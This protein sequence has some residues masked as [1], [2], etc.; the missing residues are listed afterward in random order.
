[1][2]FNFLTH[3]LSAILSGFQWEWLSH[4]SSKLPDL[5]LALNPLALPSR[6]LFLLLYGT[7][8]VY[9]VRPLGEPWQMEHQ[10]L[11]VSSVP[12]AALRVY[13]FCSVPHSRLP[14]GG[15]HV[16]CPLG[17]PPLG[18]LP[19]QLQHFPISFQAFLFS[20]AHAF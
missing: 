17:Q 12:G 14:F 13:R 8:P 16:S 19:H 20:C 7:S 4:R 2:F 11:R 5:T 3:F 6:L 9:R 18:C 10:F 1:M 15:K